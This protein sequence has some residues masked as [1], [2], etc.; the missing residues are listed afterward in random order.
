MDFPEV[1]R[2]RRM[3]RNYNGEPVEP[4]QIERIVRLARRAPSAGFSQGQSF[5]VVTEK[6]IREQIAGLVG[7]PAYVVKGLKPWMSN[8]PVHVVCCISEARYRFRYRQADKAGTAG[9]RDEWPVPWWFIDAGCSMMLLLLSAVNE[10]LAA[11]FLG[12]RAEASAPLRDL[13]SI[14]PDV[15]PYG[16]VTIGHAA[17]DRP[18]G[19]LKSGWRPEREV[20]HWQKW[21]EGEAQPEA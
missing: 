10:G 3:V 18:S 11:G 20:I 1:V 12:V 6:P 4:D 16:I 14:P 7:Q 15:E 17:P 2:R 8:A 5:V 13:L 19:S 21:T 9:A